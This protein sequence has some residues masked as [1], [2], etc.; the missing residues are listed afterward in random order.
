[1]IDRENLPTIPELKSREV[2]VASGLTLAQA[3]KRQEGDPVLGIPPRIDGAI[4]SHGEFDQDG[5]LI[6]DVVASDYHLDERIGDVL[7]TVFGDEPETDDWSGPADEFVFCRSEPPAPEGWRYFD[8]GERS[9]DF[10]RW[11]L[12]QFTSS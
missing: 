9:Q 12:G 11:K 10:A 6:C 5:N 7:K 4:V 1:M 8:T 2:I 3:L